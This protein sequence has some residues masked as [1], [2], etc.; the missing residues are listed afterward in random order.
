MNNFLET[1]TLPKL[2]QEEINLLNRPVTRNEIDYVTKTP[3]TNKT[4]EPDVFT[5]EFYQT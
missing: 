2:S 3:P 5:G 1:Y 4:A